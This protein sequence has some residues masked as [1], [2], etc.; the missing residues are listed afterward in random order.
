MKKSYLKVLTF[1]AIIVTAGVFSAC[2]KK[3]PKNDEKAGTSETAR[4]I[5][6]GTGA[7]VAP[8]SYK[9]ENGNL[10]GY[11]TEILE[12]VFARLPQYKTEFVVAEA[13]STLAG[14]DAGTYQISYNIWGY[15][16]SRAEKYLF[17]DVVRLGTSSIA[18]R[19]DNNE[20]NSVFD[21]PGHSVE[22]SPG[23]YNDTLYRNYNAAH[24]DNPIK[25]IYKDSGTGT[26][27]ALDVL[28]KKVDFWYWSTVNLR[29]AIERTGL[30]GFKIIDISP[31][32]NF[33][34]TN[35]TSGS[36]FYFP[37]GEEQLRDDFNRV[38]REL[39]ADG[40]IEKISEKYYPGLPYLLSIERLDEDAAL[41]AKDLAQ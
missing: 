6:I 20:I 35:N 17:S 27:T 34:F 28:D 1:A 21:L 24:P 12:Q 3:Q 25:I 14:L 32:D 39:V 7:A 16:K 29:Q 23:E 18:V 15:N 5:V 19:A 41:I 2:S 37:K 11:E 31:E 13:L 36:H 22:V 4:K 40:T 30:T 10:V 8:S 9:D 38:F 33:K 26:N